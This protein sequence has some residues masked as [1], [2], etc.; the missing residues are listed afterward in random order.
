MWSSEEEVSCQVALDQLWSYYLI[1]FVSTTIAFAV[2]ACAMITTRTLPNGGFTMVVS[3]WPLWVLHPYCPE[4]CEC[5][6]DESFFIIS[7]V[8]PWGYFVLGL[9]WWWYSNFRWSYCVLGIVIC[10]GQSSSKVAA[11]SQEYVVGIS[12]QSSYIAMEEGSKRKERKK[13][14]PGREP[15]PAVDSLATPMQVGKRD[16]GS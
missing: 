15:G 4:G 8:T 10:C 11:S 9:L 6:H 7:Y 5:S 13:G 3:L 1:Y 12:E 14:A 2:Q 16:I